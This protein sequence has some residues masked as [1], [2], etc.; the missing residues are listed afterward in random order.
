MIGAPG[1]PLQLVL[2]PTLW[3]LAFVALYGGHAVGCATLDVGA[4]P[5]AFIAFRTVLFLMATA[6]G[7][8]LF[9]LGLRAWR[10]RPAVGARTEGFLAR[11]AA[12]VHLTAAVS[13]PAIAAP[14]LVLPPCI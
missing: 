9:W 4:Q 5:V 7:V 6:V 11:I 2:G 13:L 10:H 14:L 3:A 12:G 1:H 8:V